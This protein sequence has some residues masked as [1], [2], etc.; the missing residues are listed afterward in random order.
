VG[1]IEVVGLVLY[2]GND[3]MCRQASGFFAGSK[4]LADLLDEKQTDVKSLINYL[5]AAIM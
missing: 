4:I 1:G 3:E 5:T 2:L